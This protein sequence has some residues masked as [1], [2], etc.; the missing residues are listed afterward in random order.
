VI[1][2]LYI[3]QRGH[4]RDI[5]LL[6]DHAPTEDKNDGKDSFYKEMECVFN[7]FQKFC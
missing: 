4:K 6:N 5:I 7:K 3:I 1:R 2:M